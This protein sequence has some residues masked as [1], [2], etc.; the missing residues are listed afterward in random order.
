M[1]RISYQN[2]MNFRHS[3]VVTRTPY[4]LPEI[5]RWRNHGELC[6]HIAKYHRGIFTEANPNTA[7][8]IGSDIEEEHAS[9]KSS[10]F[11]LA[12]NFGDSKTISE[13]IKYYFNNVASTTF[14][15]IVFDEKTQTVVEYQMNK[16]EFG[17]FIHY[18]SSPYIHKKNNKIEIRGRK[19]SKKMIKWLEAQC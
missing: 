12:E 5:D 10:R 7:F 14:I 16:S 19:D 1:K 11:G 13:A 18:F 15:Y 3:T 17:K 6:E 8:N 2:T 9:V 4:Y